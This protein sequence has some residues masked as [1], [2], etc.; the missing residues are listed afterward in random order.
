MDRYVFAMG[1]ARILYAVLNLGAAII[2]WRLN[3]A[4]DAMKVNAVFGGF[5]GPAVF[6]TVTFLG[7]AGLSRRIEPANLGLILIGTVLILWGTRG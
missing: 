2:I 1:F 3:E 6:I 5:M 4:A 7:V